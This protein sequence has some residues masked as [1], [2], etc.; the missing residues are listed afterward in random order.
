MAEGIIWTETQPKGSEQIGRLFEGL[1]IWRMEHL[2]QLEI[3]FAR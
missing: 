1:K 3:S 2:K